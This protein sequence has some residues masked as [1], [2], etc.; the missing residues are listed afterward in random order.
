M[1]AKPFKDML[2]RFVKSSGINITWTEKKIE[3]NSRGVP[4]ATGVELNFEGRV[5]FLKEKYNPLVPLNKD[6]I[7]LIADYTRYLLCAPDIKIRKDLVIKDSHDRKW[8]LG[9][10][11]WFDIGGI[12]VAQQAALTEVL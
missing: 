7:G 8:K 1:N 10:I 4:V 6:N 11:D 2:K 5:L 3:L 9:I 12:T